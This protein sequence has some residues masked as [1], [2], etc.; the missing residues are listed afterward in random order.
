MKIVGFDF[1]G[2]VSLGITPTPGDVIITGR[3]IDETEE[4]YNV[5]R[6]RGCLWT[7]VFFNPM[8]LKDR[9]NHTEEARTYSGKHK[10]NIIQK[11]KE[12]KIEVVRFFEDDE[13]QASII[14]EAHPEIEI[15][16][17]VSNLVEK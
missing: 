14:K 9:G 7:R 3:C 15:V 12:E 4:V 8:L 16:M 10:A 5:L 1:D 17:V 11:L 2:V 6:S 13:L